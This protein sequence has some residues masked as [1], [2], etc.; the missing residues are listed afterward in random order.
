MIIGY[1][2]YG[3]DNGSHM[4]EDASGLRVCGKCGYKTDYDYVNPDLKISR[5][6]YDFSSTYDGCDIVSL[7]FKEFCMREKYTGVEFMELPSDPVFFFL[8]VRNMLIFDLEKRN[9]LHENNPVFF[10][11]QCNMC[12]NYKTIVRPMPAYFKDVSSP[13]ADGLYRSDLTFA[14]GHAKSPLIIAGVDTYKKM[15]REKFRGIYAKEIKT[16]Y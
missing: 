12:G 1:L 4:Y 10:D 14:S 16:E 9:S 7:K 8:I 5:R 6:A 3:P 11:K 15:K 2:L 13:L